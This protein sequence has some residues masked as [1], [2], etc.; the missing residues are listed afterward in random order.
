MA[1]Q[2]T[3]KRLTIAVTLIAVAL[4]MI[5]LI[6][7]SSSKWTGLQAIIASGC[8]GAAVDLLTRRRAG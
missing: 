6:G 2:L 7:C 3:L 1:L 4:A 5:R 8:I